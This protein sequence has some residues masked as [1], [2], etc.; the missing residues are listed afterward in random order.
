[1]HVIGITAWISNAQAAKQPSCL[2]CTQRPCRP[3]SQ[4]DAA[5]AFPH[6]L[7]CPLSCTAEGG[8]ASPLPGTAAPP[9]QGTQRVWGSLRRAG[10]S[11]GL[12][13][14]HCSTQNPISH[15]L[16]WL[17]HHWVSS[18]SNTP[19]MLLQAL[20]HPPQ[21]MEMTWRK[22]RLVLMAL[23]NKKHIVGIVLEPV[24]LRGNRWSFR[25]G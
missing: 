15:I 11:L 9:A 18:A 17:E 10:C 7:T 22:E 8:A 1:M 13:A 25:S 21:S 4:S 2:P 19:V 6:F 3:Q 5:N 24:L 12:F 14:V 23:E 20:T 16:L